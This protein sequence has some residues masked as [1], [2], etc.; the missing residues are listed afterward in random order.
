MAEKAETDRLAVTLSTATF[1]YLEKMVK[2]GTHGNSVSGVARSLIE[3]G[4]RLAI[5]DGLVAMHRE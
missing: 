2:Q 1:G 5:R 3:E 4:V